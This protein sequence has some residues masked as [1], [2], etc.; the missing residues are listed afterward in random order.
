MF[1]WFKK[2]KTESKIANPIEIEI[3]GINPQT[4]NEYLFY[5]FVENQYAPHLEKWFEKAV[6]TGLKFKPQ[7][8]YAIRQKVKNNI[9]K[10]PHSFPGYFENKF[11]FIAIDFETANKNRISACAIGL[12]FIKDYKIVYSKKHF[13]KPPKQEEFTAFHSNIHRIYEQDV[14]QSYTFEELW[15]DEFSKYFNDNLLVFHNASMDLSILKN[16]F[17]HYSISNFD[18]E[19]IDTMQ[20][21]EKSGNPKKLTELANKF[22]IK[23]ENHHDPVEDAKVCAMIYNELIDVYP[24]YK[25]LIKTL[26]TLKPSIGENPFLR[27]ATEEIQTENK[28]YVKQYTISKTELENLEIQNNNFVVTG[29]YIFGRENVENFIT[30]NGGILKPSITP[31]INFVVIGLDY[32]WAKIQKIHDLNSTKNT[33]IKLLT[34]EEFKQLINKYGT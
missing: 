31:K 13:I 28:D 19:Y 7:Y 3:T 27:Q 34:E 20:I 23:I 24:N 11:D 8:E 14:Y 29:K 1:N 5:D 18:I 26:N 21:A 15:H 2:E 10:N 4:D 33:Q 30:Q 32:G 12:V 16:L 22:G 17:E 6:Q 9:F 25:D